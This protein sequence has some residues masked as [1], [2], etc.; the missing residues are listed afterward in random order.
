[1]PEINTGT[2]EFILKLIESLKSSHN[3]TSTSLLLPASQAQTLQRDQ[4]S[5]SNLD[6][7][8]K[9]V[10]CSPKE[11]ESTKNSN[12]NFITSDINNNTAVIPPSS[13]N[14]TPTLSK[15]NKVTKKS[16]SNKI[17]KLSEQNENL[18]NE[19]SFNVNAENCLLSTESLSHHQN[20]Q[21][22]LLQNLVVPTSSNSNTIKSLTS[23]STSLSTSS[24]P[25]LQTVLSTS[26]TSSNK[27]RHISQLEHKSN[28]KL[29][30]SGQQNQQQSQNKNVN[31]YLS[32]ISPNSQINQQQPQPQKP[33]AS[34]LT[35]KS[36]L[37]KS[38]R[39][40]SIDQLIAAA[41]VTS[42]PSTSSNN[43]H[44]SPSSPLVGSNSVDT[45]EQNLVKG[46]YSTNL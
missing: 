32:S 21:S 26:K 31:H 42:L 3:N 6:S 18:S 24:S 36:Y 34:V 13:F 29:Q 11:N 4:F 7:V 45:A 38:S 17:S 39:S 2:S 16:S 20:N 30:N 40:N 22:Y 43:T 33:I 28:H 23:C 14:T 41:A 46:N 12:P 37:I 44:E 9:V 5:T 1:M 8:V 25:T 27:I 35:N 15:S 19:N 10:E